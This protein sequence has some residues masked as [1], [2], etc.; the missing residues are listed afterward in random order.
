MPN[1]LKLMHVF[2]T[3]AVGGAQMR[4][5]MLAN[6]IGPELEHVVVSLD[7]AGGAENLVRPGIRLR[8][9][10][11]AALKGRGLSLRNL[12][13]FRRVLRDERP[14][15]LLTYNWGAIEWAL[16]DRWRPICPH[17][18][19][20][21]GFGPEEAVRQLPGRVWMRRLALSGATTVVVPAHAL[22]RLVIGTWKLDPIRVRHIPNGV[23]AAAL[24]RA[25][26]QPWGLRRPDECLLGTL[27]GLRPEKN[28]GRLL[29]IA[30]M[31]PR[32]RAWRLVIA[33]AG[34]KRADLEAQAHALGLA[35]RVVFTGFVDRPESVL[36]ELD[37]Y[38]LTSDTEQMPIG[39]LEAMA[40]GLPVLATDV[41][42]L[43]IMLPAE[44]RNICI[45]A[46]HQEKAFAD[47]LAA[48]L[49]SPG[50]R[51]RLGAL[52]RA[53]AAE[54]RVEAMVVSYDR[55]FRELA[56]RG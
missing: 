6:A 5:A 30:A 29:R 45:F 56:G 1:L 51:R 38:V 47:R 20:V 17:L 18:H 12:A 23:D 24:A 4:F 25:A 9:H 41:G 53:K 48:L 15:L 16:A 39:V 54:F 34:E 10:A 13:A 11:V 27:G 26:R 44:S 14:D 50:E 49:A 22:H 28:L 37:V 55:L 8:R 2:P 52:N 31:L 36:G 35:E 21:D 43:R 19:V 32:D 3:F 46:R 42:D 33:G 7:G 40:V